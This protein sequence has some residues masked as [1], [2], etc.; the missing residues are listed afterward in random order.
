[1]A[2]FSAAQPYILANEG[3]YC[4][5]TGDTGGETY[6]GISRNNWPN[7]GG[8]SLVDAHQPLHYNEI[9][10]DDNLN[11]LVNQFYKRNFWDTMLGDG[12]D[13]QAVATY[14]YDFHVNAGGNA[15]KCVQRVV[16]SNPDGMFG[17]GTLNALNNYSGDLLS[18]LN[19]SRI[20]YYTEISQ[21]GAN[22]K[23]LNGWLKRAND[24]YAKLSEGT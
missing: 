10:A 11:S 21:N 22:A 2:D 23:F 14:L 12:I 17:N 9:I 13:S 3:G 20:A 8:W 1:M 15:V 6:M 18:D 5:T 19:N 4:D 16:G 24:M 7:W